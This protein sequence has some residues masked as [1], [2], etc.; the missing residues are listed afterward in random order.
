MAAL[1]TFFGAL[2]RIKS[3]SFSGEDTQPVK[4]EEIDLTLHSE[5][6]EKYFDDVAF[7]EKQ[8]ANKKEETQKQRRPLN[9]PKLAFSGA[10]AV[11]SLEGTGPANATDSSC[12]ESS[13]VAG[14]CLPNGNG[15]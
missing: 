1:T 13:R 3:A 2:E 15:I 14:P 11:F 4:N 8:S 7:L 12:A 6:S 5:Q 9:K 10:G